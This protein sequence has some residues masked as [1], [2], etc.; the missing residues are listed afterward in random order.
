MTSSPI[1]EPFTLK[2]GLVLPNRLVKASTAEGLADEKYL[3]TEALIGAY[4]AW[5]DG[6]WGMV[7]TGTRDLYPN[8]R[9]Q[10]LGATPC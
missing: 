7:L 5:A 3:P 4:E 2:S 10:Q 6:G 9:S 8:L 1:S